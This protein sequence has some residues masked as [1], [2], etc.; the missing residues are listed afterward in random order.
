MPP[1]DAYGILIININNSSF[2][3]GLWIKILIGKKEIYYAY[4]N[5]TRI[6]GFGVLENEEKASD[7]II[8]YDSVNTSLIYLLLFETIFILIAFLCL[9]FI[10]RGAKKRRSY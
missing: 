9:F 3:G 8:E 4:T 6:S 10:F 7:S 2:S 1:Y 5:N